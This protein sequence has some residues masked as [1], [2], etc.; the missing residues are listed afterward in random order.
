LSLLEKYSG[1]GLPPQPGI[2][3]SLTWGAWSRLSGNKLRRIVV[4]F[5][6]LSFFQKKAK[7]YFF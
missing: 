6:K 3:I 4:F 5:A 1:A 7:R 2:F